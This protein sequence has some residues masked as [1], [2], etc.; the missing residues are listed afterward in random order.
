MLHFAMYF[1]SIKYKYLQ[2]TSTHAMWGVRVRVSKE[3]GSEGVHVST[4]YTRKLLKSLSATLQE[5]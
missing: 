2:V 5:S 3:G 1:L 4:P